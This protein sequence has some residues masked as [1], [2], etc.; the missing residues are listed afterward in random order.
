[1]INSGINLR[2]STPVVAFFVAA[3]A[4]ASCKQ[5]PPDA[6]YSPAWDT[7]ELEHAMLRMVAVDVPQAAFFGAVVA[8]SRVERAWPEEN[9]PAIQLDIYETRFRVDEVVFD[10]GVR[11][12][13]G[14]EI[15]LLD[16][17]E[18]CGRPAKS[19]LRISSCERREPVTGLLPGTSIFVL[20]GRRPTQAKHPSAGLPFTL[21]AMTRSA[22]G[23]FVQNPSAR[24]G[25]MHAHSS[26]VLRSA[27]FSSK[28]LLEQLARDRHR[29]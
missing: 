8:Q 18:D 13:A 28:S 21:A 4:V 14:T 29:Q 26:D 16:L 22:D 23:H 12:A 15:V 6:A 20:A 27:I 5:Q 10:E 9:D 24:F 19:E 25:A 3:T 1:M 11:V 7:G 2:L 17:T